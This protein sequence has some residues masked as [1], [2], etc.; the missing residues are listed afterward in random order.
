MN[1]WTAVEFVFAN[2]TTG[3]GEAA[4]VGEGWCDCIAPLGDGQVRFWAKSDGSVNPPMNVVRLA[5][6]FAEYALSAEAAAR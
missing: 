5:K 6:P 2:G 3:P 4:D 1:T